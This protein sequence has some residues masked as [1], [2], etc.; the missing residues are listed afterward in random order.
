MIANYHTHTVRCRHAA[1]TE[2][3]MIERAIA[4]G[5][6]ILG[7][8]DHTP[9]W[10]GETDF[11]SH[12]RM[13]PDQLEDYFRTLSDLR[14]EYRGQIELKIGLEV[15]YYPAYFETL[16]DHLR[17][18]APDY[19][20][21]GQHFVG[22]EADEQHIYSGALTTDPSIL[23]GYCSQVIEAMQTGLFSYVAHPDL[24]NFC[25]D[26]DI[27]R[28]QMRRICREAVR[29]GLPV[30]VNF[31]GIWNGRNYPNPLFWQ[32]AGEEGVTAVFGCDA[33]RVTDV[34]QPDTEKIA[35][36][37]LDENGIRRTDTV[38]LR[39]VF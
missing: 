20:L 27:Y 29:L 26:P 23:E 3:E 32:V 24:M 17:P 14:D 13:Y 34:F 28:R 38:S 39:P 16:L 35:Q 30:E 6:Q 1:D 22:N 18:F 36:R 4:S 12:F 19:F 25:G 33:H 2:R 9:Y 21:L 8:S 10:F 7:F 15:E 11:Y 5:L 31:L 37:I